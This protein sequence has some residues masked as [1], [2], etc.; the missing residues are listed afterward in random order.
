M[1][2]ILPIKILTVFIFLISEPYTEPINAQTD[3]LYYLDSI[4]VN[5]P[6]FIGGELT[7]R[8]LLIRNDTLQLSY[9]SKRFAI[10]F[11]KIRTLE[12][13]G[14]KKSN[15]WQGALYGGL[16]GGL[17]LGI[18]S[19]AQNSGN[20]KGWFT[21]SPSTAFAI[22]F[23]SGG[24]IGSLTGMLIGSQTES[25]NFRKVKINNIRYLHKPRP[26]FYYLQTDSLLS[27]K[28]KLRFFPRNKKEELKN[29]H[30][31]L[32]FGGVS[33]GASKDFETAMNTQN[34]NDTKPVYGL[35]TAGPTNY[36]YFPKSEKGLSAGIAW[37]LKGSY[38]LNKKYQAG[39]IFGNAPTGN[40]SGYK[41]D[42]K[43]EVKMEYS[44]FLISPL[45]GVKITDAVTF[46]VGPAIY[47]NKVKVSATSSGTKSKFGA[48]FQFNVIYPETTTFYAKLDAQFRLIPKSEFGPFDIPAREI[49]RFEKF[50]ADFSHFFLGIGL[51]ISF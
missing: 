14:F 19:A 5:A 28:H 49:S 46:A 44:S 22:G 18:I 37:T 32:T 24:L 47:F 29:F 20:E 9:Y 30:L 2:V 12:V 51:G 1:K 33:S 35:F 21:F 43:Y 3:S 39:I 11:D 40:T 50:E 7:G 23:V 16:A 13:W 26:G 6:A 10:P 17:T 38:D 15:T 4:K 45:F 8:L 42:I 41:K 31:D 27:G 36:E 34:W 48:L 25:I